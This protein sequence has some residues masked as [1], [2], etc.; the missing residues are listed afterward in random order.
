MREQKTAKLL[1]CLHSEIITCLPECD[2]LDH[3]EDEILQH[4][5]YDKLKF[6]TEGD[7]DDEAAI[8]GKTAAQRLK[9]IVK[10]LPRLKLPHLAY[11]FV[12]KYDKSEVTKPAKVSAIKS[13]INY[14][15]KPRSN[16]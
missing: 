13:P 7:E 1:Q 9:D 6:F 4:I 10:M 16:S 11:D 12:T 14:A 2:K 5:F 3:Q 15:K 8:D